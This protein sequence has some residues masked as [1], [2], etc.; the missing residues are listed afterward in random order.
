LKT[1]LRVRE[2]QKEKGI[3]LPDN[4]VPIKL[5]HIIEPNGL[6]NSGP[7]EKFLLYYLEKER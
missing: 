3:E 6:V 1:K 7:S 4:A 2:I 5:E